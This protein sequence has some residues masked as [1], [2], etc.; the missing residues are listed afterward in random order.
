[1]GGHSTGGSAGAPGGGGGGDGPS[2][3]NGEEDPIEIQMQIRKKK[4]IVVFLQPD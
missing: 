3:C 2:D 4:M 1:M